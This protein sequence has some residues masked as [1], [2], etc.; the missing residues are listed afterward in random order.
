M[1]KNKKMLLFNNQ[2]YW[3]VCLRSLDPLYRKSL[4]IN[5]QHLLG[6]KSN[7]YYCTVCP[8]SFD[9]LYIESH[10]ALID[11]TFW[12][13][14]HTNIIVLYVQEVLTNFIYYMFKK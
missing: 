8:R 7:K 4:C 13:Y 11:N 5:R 12:A 10:Y 1:I 9:P 14:S 2:N 6:I 3:T